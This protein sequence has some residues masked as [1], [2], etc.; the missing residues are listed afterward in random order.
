MLEFS[1]CTGA[2][3]Y[4][5]LFGLNSSLCKL[6]VLCASV[7]ICSAKHTTETQR[8]QRLHR[9]NLTYFYIADHRALPGVRVP[10][11]SEHVAAY[12]ARTPVQLKSKS[13]QCFLFCPPP[14]AQARQ[15]R[16]SMLPR[17]HQASM[18]DLKRLQ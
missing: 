18:A 8:T 5:S 15:H 4:W 1:C 7:V 11:G 17:F 14:P 13:L 3:I 16:E 12:Q 6:C 2:L 9:E 10:P